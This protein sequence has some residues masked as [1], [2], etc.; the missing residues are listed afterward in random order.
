MAQYLYGVPRRSS[1]TPRLVV[2]RFSLGP[3]RFQVAHVDITQNVNQFGVLDEDTHVAGDADI[4]LESSLYRVHR[5]IAGVRVFNQEA[6][7]FVYCAWYNLSK[8]LGGA[9]SPLV[10]RWRLPALGEAR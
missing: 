6:A 2:G 10:L 7:R 4:T 8:R 1:S 5:A 9:G 3:L